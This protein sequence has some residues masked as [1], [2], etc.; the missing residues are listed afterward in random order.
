MPPQG[1]SI[2]KQDLSRYRLQSICQM[3]R[4][5]FP[6]EVPYLRQGVRCRYRG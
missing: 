4:T 5:R 6:L 2:V 3:G 1:K